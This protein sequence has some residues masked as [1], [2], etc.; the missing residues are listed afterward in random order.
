MT[1]TQRILVALVL[2]IPQ[3]TWAGTARDRL[4][5]FAKG[6]DAL[7]GRFEQSVTDANGNPQDQSSGTVALQAPR[8]FRWEYAEPFPQL[9]V[10]DGNN[11]WVWDKDLDQVTV[12]GQALEESQSPRT[13]LTDLSLLEREYQ[14]AERPDA[15]G[16]AWLRLTPTA[17]EAPI[18]HCDLGMSDT[19]LARM[20]LTDHLGQRNEIRFL[21]WQRNPQLA[22]DLF[23]FTPPKGVD[24]V[25]E[26]VKSAEVFPVR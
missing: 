11:V 14:V 21:D 18:Q 16:L 4:D 3:A 26:P 20:V 19:G 2:G 9:I 13:V 25:G 12:R 1:R 6:L 23:R 17:D 15:D 7:S 22:P 8:Q 24:V 10:A 5:A